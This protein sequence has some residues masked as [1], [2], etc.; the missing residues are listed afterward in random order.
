MSIVAG[1]GREEEI[2]N[3]VWAERVGQEDAGELGEE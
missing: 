1:G 3:A 2:V